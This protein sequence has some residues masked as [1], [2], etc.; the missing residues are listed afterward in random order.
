MKTTIKLLTACCSL[1]GLLLSGCDLTVLNENPNQP[2]T[3][4]DDIFNFNDARLAGAFRGTL[5]VMEGDDEQRIKSLIIDFY[6]QMLDGGNYD[7]KNYYPNEDWNQRMYRRVQSGVSG[8]NIVLRNLKG[9]EDEFA[10]SMSVAKIWRVYVQSIGVDYFGPI[11]FATYDSMEINPPYKSVEDNYKEFFAEL[12]EA[13]ELLDQGSKN[14]FVTENADLLYKN[15]VEMWKRFASSLRLRL[16]M[17]LSE[18][19]KSLC[20]AE[21]TK[22]LSAGVME[23]AENNARIA[24]RADGGWGGDYNYTMFQITWS[25]PLSMTSSFEKL[26]E[27]LGGIEWMGSITN[28]R[29]V[30]NKQE[31]EKNIDAN[32]LHPTHI[33]PRATLMFDPPYT[34]PKTGGNAWQG[35]PVGLPKGDWDKEDYNRNYYPELGILFRKGLPYKSRPY[36][37]FLY[38]EVCFL[39]AEAYLR[40]FAAGNAK[41]AYEE[42]IRASFATWKVDDLVVEEYLTSTNKNGAGTS[43][44]F[45]DTEEGTGNTQ[46]EKI[47]TQ[48]Y[49]AL[50]PDMAMEAWN[51]KRRLNLPRMDVPISRNPEHYGSSDNDI[52][53]PQNFIKRVQY[54]QNEVQIN[55]EEYDKGVALLGGKDVVSTPIWWDK[56]SNYCTSAE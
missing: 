38:E 42:G 29:A 50:F 21:V 7:T 16:A 18:V 41:A 10:K 37:V 5:P 24:P 25:G 43:V 22:A 20:T 47:I 1:C 40:G 2:S 9:K 17:R 34:K 54:P 33:D 35:L 30:Y 27:N 3:E 11:P 36:D 4:L 39:K 31:T 46:L 6:A 44:N 52:K 8:L 48:K 55:K 49:L 15:D 14:I 56:N 19:D 13:L 26:V 45:D 23:S 53:K 12:D 28:Q 51:D 32:Y